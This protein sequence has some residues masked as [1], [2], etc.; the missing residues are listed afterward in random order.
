[1]KSVGPATAPAP[2]P[3]DTTGI[4]PQP[5]TTPGTDTQKELS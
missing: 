1:M 3:P 5:R 4:H 2:H